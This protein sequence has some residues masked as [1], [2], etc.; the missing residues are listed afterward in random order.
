MG[1]FGPQ[2]GPCPLLRSDVGTTGACGSCCRLSR[3]L[4]RLD[5]SCAALLYTLGHCCS[6]DHWAVHPCLW[7][8]FTQTTHTGRLVRSRCRTHHG[9]C[10]CYMI[11]EGPEHPSA[12]TVN[13][14]CTGGYH[15][16]CPCVYWLMTAI[17]RKT[18]LRLATVCHIIFSGCVWR[19]HGCL[20]CFVSRN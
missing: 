12:F 19:N 10:C 17:A 7:P 9:S 6:M 1:S 18:H 11:Q 14:A 8:A 16:L 2:T 5:G 4:G 20:Q 3:C 13:V 15:T